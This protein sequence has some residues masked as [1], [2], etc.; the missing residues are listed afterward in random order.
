MVELSD[1]EKK[2]MKSLK[3]MK[4]ASEEDVRNIYLLYRKVIDKPEIVK[5]YESCNCPGLIREMAF[6]LTLFSLKNKSI[7]K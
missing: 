2:F 4:E 3:K 5:E 1:E 7:L 6:E